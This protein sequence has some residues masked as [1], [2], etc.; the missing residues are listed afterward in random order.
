MRK[1]WRFK[2]EK[3]GADIRKN[4]VA[5]ADIFVCITWSLCGGGDT[6][7]RTHKHVIERYVVGDLSW[8]F[9]I[10]PGNLS[11][12]YELTHHT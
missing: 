12:Y 10:P 8:D 2:H 7:T 3:H 1:M 9:H 11:I 6:H 4:C 5:M